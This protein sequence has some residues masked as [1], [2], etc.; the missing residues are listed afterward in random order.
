M[1]RVFSGAVHS[2]FRHARAWTNT[3]V[4]AGLDLLLCVELLERD[5][6]AFLGAVFAQSGTF[7]DGLDCMG[8]VFVDVRNM[9]LHT[10]KEL[11]PSFQWGDEVILRAFIHE[12]REV[13]AAVQTFE[14]GE[15]R[16]VSVD[17]KSGSLGQ[18]AGSIEFC[19]PRA[20][21]R[22]HAA[23]ASE[24]KFDSWSVLLLYELE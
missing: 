9:K 3:R 23:R 24:V 16:D 6:F 2:Q 15:H 14:V 8:N 4:G 22:L 12:D 17:A 11:S 7:A 10:L 19:L 13:F 1:R 21:F 18:S 5:V 20:C